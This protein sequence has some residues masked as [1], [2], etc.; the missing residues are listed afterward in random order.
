MSHTLAIDVGNSRLKWALVGTRGVLAHGAVPNAEIGSL[1]VRDWQN[2]ARPVRAVGVNVAG[3]AARVR[4]EGQLSRW[5]LPV[6]WITPTAEACGVRNGYDVPSQLGADRW[7]SLVAARQRILLDGPPRPAIVVNAGTAVTVDA[8]DQ[9]GTFRGGLILPNIR[10]MLRVL[11]E[12]TSALKLPPGRHADFPAN[13]PDA[14]YTGA[15]QAICGAIE[16]A[17][18]RLPF[19]GTPAKCFLAGGVAPEIAPHLTAP[20]ELVDNLVLEGVLVLADA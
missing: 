16:L 13:T 12:N 20:V 17:R 1:A 2:L 18:L 5:R 11:A 9:D 14:L 6:E 4:V 19:D 15:V 10:L 8:L 7:A 3:E